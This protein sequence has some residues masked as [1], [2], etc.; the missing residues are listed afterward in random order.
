MRR[1]R[2]HE[3]RAPR[4]TRSSPP[5]V[6]PATEKE[7]EDGRARCAARQPAETS[8]PHAEICSPGEVQEQPR[9][10]VKCGARDKGVC[11]CL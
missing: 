7:K 3:S 9:R 5:D 1:E 8:Y 4:G 6:L 2:S 10:N 11:A